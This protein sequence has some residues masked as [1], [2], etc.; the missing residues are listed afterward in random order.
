MQN[1]EAAVANSVKNGVKF[2]RLE[3]PEDF[4][5]KAPVMSGPLQLVKTL[6]A[7]HLGSSLP[8]FSTRRGWKGVYNPKAGWTHAYNSLLALKNEC[9]RLGVHFIWGPSGTAKNVMTSSTGKAIGIMTENGTQ[10]KADRIIL[11]CGAWMDSI[12]DM[13]GQCLAKRSVL[14]TQIIVWLMLMGR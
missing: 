10:H 6:P 4:R 12:V 2:E 11:A 14:Y 7:G 13:K 9:A 1:Y 8:A 3:K 5:A